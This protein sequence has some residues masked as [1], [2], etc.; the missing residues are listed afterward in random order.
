MGVG[1][2]GGRRAHRHRLHL[3]GVDE[4][5]DPGVAGALC[6]GKLCGIGFEEFEKG[7]GEH[8]DHG[9]HGPQIAVSYR[10]SNPL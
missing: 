3:V 4:R 5:G 6:R 10:N 2:P 1:E 8:V 9:S 7:I